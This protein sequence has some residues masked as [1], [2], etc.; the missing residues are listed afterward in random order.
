[1]IFTLEVIY[2]IGFVILSLIHLFG[3]SMLGWAHISYNGKFLFWVPAFV[4]ALFFTALWPI[5]LPIQIVQST[6]R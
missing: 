1:M 3:G 4:G 2:W 6:R 5:I